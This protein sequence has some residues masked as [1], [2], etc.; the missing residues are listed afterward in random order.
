MRYEEMV[1]S[2]QYIRRLIELAEQLASNGGSAPVADKDF[3]IVPPGDE[4]RQES[5]MR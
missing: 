3:L 2:D 4:I 1:G 5:F